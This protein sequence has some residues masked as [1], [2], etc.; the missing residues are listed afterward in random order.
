MVAKEVIIVNHDLT[1]YPV[2]KL[3]DFNQLTTAPCEIVFKRFS[4]F[5]IKERSRLDHQEFLINFSEAFNQA[6]CSTNNLLLDD[7]IRHPDRLRQLPLPKR[8]TSKTAMAID[9]ITQANGKI[10]DQQ[11]FQLVRLLRINPAV[12]DSEIVDYQNHD[13]VLIACGAK[14]SLNFSHL[15]LVDSA[16]LTTFD[17]QKLLNIIQ[18]LGSDRL[19]N[20]TQSQFPKI[21]TIATKLFIKTS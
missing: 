17:G 13:Q 2:I 21:Q 7:L 1:V 8:Q 3:A 20:L 16:E 9:L 4:H 5:V 14:I 15:S 11:R 12:V 19:L 10:S 6:N 18:I